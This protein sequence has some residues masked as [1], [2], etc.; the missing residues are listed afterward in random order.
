MAK[1]DLQ[2]GTDGQD[3]H[4]RTTLGSEKSQ[5]VVIAIDGDDAVAPVDASFGIKA[6]ISRI[7]A[8]DTNIGNVDVE[9]VVPG[10]A[11]SSLGKAED[12]AH[13]TGHTGVFVLAVRKDTA[14]AQ[15][16]ADGDYH[17]LLVDGSGRLHTTIGSMPAAARTVDSISS[18]L[19][20]DR[21]MNNLTA[22]T[23]AYA[24][25]DAATSGD[26]TLLSAQ[27]SGNKI[28]VHSLFVVASAAVTIRFESGAGGTA[29]TGQMQLAANGGFVL[30]F[31]PVGWFETA[32]N[33]LLNLEL[34]GAISV[35]GNFQYTVVT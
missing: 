31:N 7:A 35:D 11:G 6:D 3:V 10:T 22:V 33:T 19:A 14:A 13:S 30:P 17:A 2:T 1:S 23:P 15:A 20:V 34:S 18:A 24:I 29:L 21:L 9:S 16:D 4:A 25:I 28:R 32:G 26:N 5:A 8:G 12:A 27:G